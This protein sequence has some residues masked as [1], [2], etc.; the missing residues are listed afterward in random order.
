MRRCAKEGVDWPRTFRD[1]ADASPAAVTFC[2]DS[3]SDPLWWQRRH[4]EWWSCGIT[5]QDGLFC[6]RG[7]VMEHLRERVKLP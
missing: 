2:Y 7:Y 5:P 6:T 4:V 3:G 1:A